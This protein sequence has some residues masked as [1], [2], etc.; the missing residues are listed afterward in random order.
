MV[1]AQIKEVGHTR[2]QDVVA[3]LCDRLF[4][5]LVGLNDGIHKKSQP[6]FGRLANVG[7]ASLHLIQR[8][9]ECIVH[10]WRGKYILANVKIAHLPGTDPMH[11]F[12]LVCSLVTAASRGRSRVFAF[13]DCKLPNAH[14]T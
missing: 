6:N 13:R 9:P 1:V 10:L 14:G 5:L 3:A 7:R 4:C 12:S 2:F 8:N 11:F